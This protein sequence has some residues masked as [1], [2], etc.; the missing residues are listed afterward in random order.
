[1]QYDLIGSLVRELYPSDGLQAAYTTVCP[2]LQEK[3]ITQ[4][5]L[6]HHPNYHRGTQHVRVLITILVKVKKSP[7]IRK[8]LI[9]LY[10]VVIDNNYNWSRHDRFGLISS[11]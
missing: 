2:A 1:M 8:L 4:Q 6:A 11:S 9:K 7:K 10:L 3:S 5:Q